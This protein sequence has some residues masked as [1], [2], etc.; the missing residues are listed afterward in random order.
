MFKNK[1][2]ST[3]STIN[4]INQVYKYL[5]YKKYKDKTINHPSFRFIF[6]SVFPYCLRNLYWEKQTNKEF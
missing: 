6:D 3:V 5:S 4:T 2:C 1:H